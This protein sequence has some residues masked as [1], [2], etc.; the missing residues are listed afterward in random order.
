MD[1][2]KSGE[3]IAD[4]R[5]VRATP[6]RLLVA[7]VS[8]LSAAACSGVNVVHKQKLELQ[9]VNLPLR[10]FAFASGL[11]VVVEK[12]SRTPLA[13][14][15]AVVGSGS[16]SDPKGKEGL[17]HY[18]EHLAF[19]SRPLGQES[20]G[21]MLDAAG[22]IARN[23]STNFD[24]T[25][26]Y[27]IGPASALPQLLRAEAV[28]MVIPVSNV[29]DPARRIELDVVQNELRERNETGFIGGVFSELQ[30]AIFPSGHPNASPIGGTH[31]SVSTFTKADVDAFARAHYRPDNMTLVV[32]GNVDLDKAESLLAETLPA[33]LVAAPQPARLPE[34]LAA[35]PPAV[36]APPPRPAQILQVE[37]AIPSPELWVGW[38]L[39]RGFDRDG[40]LLSFLASA[41]RQRFSRLRLDDPDITSVDVVPVPGKDAS[42]LLCRVELNQA[43]DPEKTLRG[44]LGEAPNVVN[45]FAVDP[46]DENISSIRGSQYTYSDVAY[47]RARRTILVGE[48]LGM[49]DLIER[50]LR[51]ATV[52]H[53]SQDPTLLSHALRDL[54]ELKPEKFSA[55]AR[56][57]LTPERARAVLFVPN[58]SGGRLAEG[59]A[60]VAPAERDD[61]SEKLAAPSKEWIT[62]LLTSPG[63]LTSQRLPNGLSVV[64]VRRPGLPLVSAS[65]SLGV[66]S[67][68]AKEVGA[69]A[70]ARAMAFPASRVNVPSEYGGNIWNWETED[71]MTETVEGSSGN[72]EAV[73]ATLAERVRSEHVEPSSSVQY[74]ESV[75]PSYQRRER[76][77]HRLADRAFLSSVLPDSPYGHVPEYRELEAAS[78]A[79]ANDW[80]D[81][82][83]VPENATLIVVGDFEPK[84]M[85][86]FVEDSFGRWRGNGAPAASKT[87][88]EEAQ[89]RGAVRT[90][91]TPRPGATQGEVRF[92]CQLP[93]VSAGPVAVRHDLAAAVARGLLHRVLRDKLGASYGVHARAVELAGGTAYLDLQTSVENGKLPSALRELRRFLDEMAAT[94]IDEQ[95]LGWARYSKASSVALSQ[96]SNSAVAFSILRRTS[97][98][99]SPDLAE[100]G[101]DLGAVSAKDLQSDFRHCLGAH[102]T[103][104]IVGEPAVVQSAL[105]EGWR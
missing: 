97:L 10:T 48:I 32:L 40:Y 93:A 39:P 57:Y 73:L 36:P 60:G 25:T 34:R 3:A 75:L 92:G 29:P 77:P 65:I 23:A 8:L 22:A 79:V 38:S 4:R 99:L 21:D 49:Q 59:S 46:N 101:R 6:N 56:P 82:T 15:F 62:E 90:V 78:P 81:R 54:A 43:R 27:E 31:Q 85:Q 96:M 42:L 87:R 95:T 104:S 13:G 63:Q 9:P 88:P 2:F 51:R 5:S 12:D 37:A 74:K 55:Y 47:S 105:K 71:S 68:V 7:A 35:V 19:Q 98:G 64:L 45:A 30:G 66:G 86:G 58:G 102:A 33:A 61:K 100:V 76:D 26:F 91:T 17:A 18:V 72:A 24:A 70:L 103:L 67:A 52:T 53:F 11:R 50:G 28:R 1:R 84:Q 69:R 89:D 44:V 94:P 80:I 83:H 14:V 41:A 16:S 20:F